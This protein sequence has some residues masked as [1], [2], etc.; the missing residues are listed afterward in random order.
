MRLLLA[1]IALVALAG[2]KSKPSEAPLPPAVAAPK[3]VGLTS[4]GSTLDVI[5]SRVA[6]AVTIAR[7]ANTAG[8]P[9]VVEEELSVASSF[10]PKPTEGDLAYARQRSE[11]AEAA[12]A[13]LEKQ[14][15]ANKAALAARDARIVELAA[16]V[17]R[18]KKDKA[19]QL[20]TMAGVGVAVIGALATAFASPKVGVP[21]LLCGGAI[22]AFPFVVD[23][24]W[25]AWIAGAFAAVLAV[26]TPPAEVEEEVGRRRLRRR[27]GPATAATRSTPPSPRSPRATS[28]ARGGA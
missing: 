17:E 28:C 8:K 3:E 16:E 9:T 2:C 27:P 6:A 22:G 4:V 20:W 21:L 11:K 12:W 7:E 5:D 10:L 18:V 19:A 23:S 1:V 24:P 15:A 25:F 26:L 13:D 14:V